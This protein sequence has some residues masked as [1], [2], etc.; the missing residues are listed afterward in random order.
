[1]IRY[2]YLA[3]PPLNR[4]MVVHP[5]RDHEGVIDRWVIFCL[6]CR[7]QFSVSADIG[8]TADASGAVSTAKSFEC[9]RCHEWRVRIIFGIVVPGGVRFCFSGGFPAEGPMRFAWFTCKYCS[10]E[11][12]ASELLDEPPKDDAA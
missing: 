4:R 12:R 2:Y 10:A 8:V 5:L 11:G 9:S 7:E 3:P 6:A 1:M